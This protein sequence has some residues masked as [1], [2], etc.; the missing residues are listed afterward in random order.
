MGPSLPGYAGNVDSSEDPWSEINGTVVQNSYDS[1]SNSNISSISSLSASSSD[2]DYKATGPNE[3]EADADSLT[4]RQSVVSSGDQLQN[5]GLKLVLGDATRA[6]SDAY[7]S[8]FGS[9]EVNNSAITGVGNEPIGSYWDWDD[10]D[11]R[12]MDIQALLSEFGD[13]GDF[14]ENDVLPFGE[15]SAYIK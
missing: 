15:V 12:G 13:F 10:D 14:F 1:S 8:D 11:D 3:L 2:S 6:L 9:M 7:M 5:D 4:C